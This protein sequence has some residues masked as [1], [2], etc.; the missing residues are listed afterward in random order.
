MR[1]TE[2]SEYQN[3]LDKFIQQKKAGIMPT[4]EELKQLSIESLVILVNTKLEE[5]K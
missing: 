3:N 2:R 5:L 1:P 4:I